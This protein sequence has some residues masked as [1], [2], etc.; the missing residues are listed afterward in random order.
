MPTLTREI[1]EA[2]I[3]GFE[4]QKQR[5]DAQIS[6]LRAMLKG[7][8]ST[9]ETKGGRRKR[10]LSPKLCSECGRDSSAD[11]RG[12]RACHRRPTSSRRKPREGSVRRAKRQLSR[13]LRNAG[14]RR[15]PA[16]EQRLPGRRQGLRRRR[17]Y[18]RLAAQRQNWL[19]AG[20]N[21]G[22][23]VDFLNRR[24]L[25]DTCK[26]TLRDC[27][28]AVGTDS[29]AGQQF[30]RFVHVYNRRSGYRQIC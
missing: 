26:S 12:L 8:D 14:R 22:L 30:A 3:A 9:T 17:S 18:A 4:S 13:H 7:A 15:R 24:D 20:N 1:I 10:K 19:G 23:Q 2:A 21:S 28:Y 11:G 29:D 5:I 6:E 16:A 25:E 27:A